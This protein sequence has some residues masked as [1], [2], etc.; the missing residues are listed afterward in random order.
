MR[1]YRIEHCRDRLGPFCNGAL[2]HPGDWYIFSD[3]PIP[4]VD[5]ECTRLMEMPLTARQKYYF[6]FNT[7]ESLHTSWRDDTKHRLHNMGYVIGVYDISDNTFIIGH[8]KTQ[9]AFIQSE[10]RLI[11]SNSLIKGDQ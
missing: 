5:F 4:S 2:D 10:A 6:A 11:E 8:S 7:L 3:I 9:V 1:V